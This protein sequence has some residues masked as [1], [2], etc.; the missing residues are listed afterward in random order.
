MP[1]VEALDILIWA[2][3]EDSPGARSQGDGPPPLE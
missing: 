1:S 2:R 3:V